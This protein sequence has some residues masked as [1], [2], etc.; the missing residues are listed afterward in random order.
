M[1]RMARH[2]ASDCSHRS[3]SWRLFTPRL[4]SKQRARYKIREDN[5][6]WRT[7]QHFQ[8]FPKRLYLHSN[9]QPGRGS[10]F[11]FKPKGSNLTVLYWKW[12]GW[13]CI[14][15]SNQN[16]HSSAL[17]TISISGKPLPFKVLS[18]KSCDFRGSLNC[19][20]LQ[21]HHVRNRHSSSPRPSVTTHF[22]QKKSILLPVPFFSAA[23]HVCQTSPCQEWNN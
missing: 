10:H 4:A 23:N 15:N 2:C 21:L 16:K 12:N 18:F 7:S 1:F 11:R 22:L 5:T 3:M 8:S 13:E 19:S 14:D 17:K 20:R 6:P 9:H